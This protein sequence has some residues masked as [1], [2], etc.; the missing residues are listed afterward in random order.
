ML[1]KHSPGTC[2]ERAR[3][4][5]DFYDMLAEVQ[6]EHEYVAALL[7]ELKTYADRTFKALRSS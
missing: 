7:L 5:S 3:R 1:D 4:E 6:S 2:E